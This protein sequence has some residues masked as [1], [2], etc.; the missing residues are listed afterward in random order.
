MKQDDLIH[1]IRR[2]IVKARNEAQHY[3]DQER[4]FPDNEL[5]PAWMELRNFYEG[6]VTAFQNC[7]MMAEDLS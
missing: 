5:V 3:A 2:K 7:L 4:K 1:S 6:R